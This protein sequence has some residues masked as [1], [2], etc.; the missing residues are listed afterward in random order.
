[1][2][3]GGEESRE[4]ASYLW[5]SDSASGDNLCRLEKILRRIKKESWKITKGAKTK[6]RTKGT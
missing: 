6:E 3:E 1:M 2:S 5:D 4:E